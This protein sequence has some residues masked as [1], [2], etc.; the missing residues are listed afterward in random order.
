[1]KKNENKTCRL[2]LLKLKLY[3]FTPLHHYSSGDHYL[4]LYLTIHQHSYP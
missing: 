4:P 1:M 2:L 3:L